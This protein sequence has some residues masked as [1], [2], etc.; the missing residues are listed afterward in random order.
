MV[1]TETKTI[2]GRVELTQDWINDSDFDLDDVKKLMVN[3]IKN[4]I[5]PI[6]LNYESDA[7]NMILRVWEVDE[8]I[9]QQENLEVKPMFRLI[10]EEDKEYLEIEVTYTKMKDEILHINMLKLCE[11]H[12]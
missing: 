4:V 7:E 6:P 8:W 2:K 11:K 12:K 1:K 9:R 10:K 5:L 3:A